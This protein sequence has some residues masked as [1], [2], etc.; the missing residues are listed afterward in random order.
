[1]IA[2]AFA[3]LWTRILAKPAPAACALAV[4]LQML[5]CVWHG[6][7]KRGRYWAAAWTCN[8]LVPPVVLLAGFL[9][10]MW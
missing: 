10:P 2:G 5:S 1:M 8:I 4:Q 6:Y 9:L 7:M 3:R